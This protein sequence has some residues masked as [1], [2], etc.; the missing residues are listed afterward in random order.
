MRAPTP[1]CAGG[2]DDDADEV[3]DRLNQL[4]TT[5]DKEGA[6]EAIASEQQLREEHMERKEQE[7]RSLQF[8]PK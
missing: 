7:V 1:P 2:E 8:V 3:T 6:F 5:T 4:D